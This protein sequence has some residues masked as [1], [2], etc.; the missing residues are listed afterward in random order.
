M[1]MSFLH[2]CAYFEYLCIFGIITSK[3]IYCIFFICIFVQI[4]HV[5]H[6]L[7]LLIAAYF[8]HISAYFNLPVIL[9]EPLYIIKHIA[10]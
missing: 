3:H 7:V 9:Y 1:H 5:L 2:M 10:H 4:L 6:C 8:I